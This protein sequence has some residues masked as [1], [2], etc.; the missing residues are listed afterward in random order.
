MLL[1]L[2]FWQHEY[3]IISIINMCIYFAEHLFLFF[4]TNLI[5]I[6]FYHLFTAFTAFFFFI[7][8]HTVSS[9]YATYRWD[10]LACMLS[11]PPAS[12]HFLRR[13]KCAIQQYSGSQEP[14]VSKCGFSR[15]NSRRFRGGRTAFFQNIRASLPHSRLITKFAC[16]VF[17]EIEI[18]SHL[19]SPSPF[20]C[21]L[22]PL[23]FILRAFLFSMTFEY[24]IALS[25]ECN[26]VPSRKQ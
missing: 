25:W 2:I 22:I 24:Y 11:V 8:W 7:S 3:I 16:T 12:S 14:V 5:R 9:V 15:A 6:L 19:I 1:H 10:L 20:K 18:T 4:M 13:A 17:S 21:A 23:H 26:I